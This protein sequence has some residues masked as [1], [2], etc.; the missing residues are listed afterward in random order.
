MDK[1]LGGLWR[2]VTLVV[3]ATCCTVVVGFLFFGALVFT[4]KVPQFQF[5]AA[6]L[7]GSV[8]YALLKYRS[9]RDAL[10]VAALL[11]LS[12]FLLHRTVRLSV[13]TYSLFLIAGVVV[14]VYIYWRF[15]EGAMAEVRVGKFLAFASLFVPGHSIAIAGTGSLVG[16][17]KLKFFVL[18]TLPISFLI[19]VGLGLGLELFRRIESRW[20]E[21]GVAEVSG[22]D[23]PEKE[24][25]SSRA[26]GGNPE[27]GTRRS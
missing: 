14:S 3:L 4:T 7:T 20:G 25:E 13:N 19:G 6:G 8:V 5:L 11:Y 21:R 18:R 24:T 12:T 9:Q 15:L 27:P 22:S 17:Q 2:A 10:F 1:N 23:T 16:V 26:Q